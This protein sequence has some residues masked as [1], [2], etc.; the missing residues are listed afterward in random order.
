VL[1]WARGA[2]KSG[3]VSYLPVQ[4]K[5]RERERGGERDRGG[6]RERGGERGKVVPRVMPAPTV[7][8]FLPTHPMPGDCSP[9]WP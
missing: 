3:F 1:R 7:P 9:H 6:E 8:S 5:P 2:E 4:L